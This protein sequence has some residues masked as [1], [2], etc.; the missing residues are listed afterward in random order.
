MMGRFKSMGKTEIIDGKTVRS[1]IL[2]PFTEE[3]EARRDAEEKA[4]AE[5]GLKA[6]QWRYIRHRRDAYLKRTD[7]SQAP[8]GSQELKDKYAVYRQALRDIPQ[9]NPDD[10]QLIIDSRIKLKGG[11]VSEA[12]K[13]NPDLDGIWPKE[14]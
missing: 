1:R 5:T 2:V 10:P 14:P 9:K 8:D 4:W 3:E 11:D 7:F 13:D 6:K 12:N